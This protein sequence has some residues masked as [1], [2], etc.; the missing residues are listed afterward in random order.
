MI[1]RIEL[2]DNLKWIKTLPDYCVECPAC[3]LHIPIG[4]PCAC[5]V[6]FRLSYGHTFCEWY[7]GNAYIMYWDDGYMS[8]QNSLEVLYG[9]IQPIN[10]QYLYAKSELLVA[11]E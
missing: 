6:K 2:R 3:M 1:E 4:H 5:K 7:I 10:F 8:I 11:F 9:D